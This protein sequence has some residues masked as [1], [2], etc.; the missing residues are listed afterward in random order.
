MTKSTKRTGGG[1]GPSV[2]AKWARR[3]RQPNY[4]Y[5]GVCSAFRCGRV[6]SPAVGAPS[7]LEGS[8]KPLSSGKPSSCLEEHGAWWSMGQ[9]WE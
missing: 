3:L 9:V 1:V 6:Q 7:S 2:G 5:A 8:G 4:D